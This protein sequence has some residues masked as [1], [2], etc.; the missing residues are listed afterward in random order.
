MTTDPIDWSSTHWGEVGHNVH[1]A[2]WAPDGRHDDE[3][4]DQ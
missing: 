2:A 3:T 1:V 4:S